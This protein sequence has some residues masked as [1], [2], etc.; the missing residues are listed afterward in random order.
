MARTHARTAIMRLRES[1]SSLE[2]YEAAKETGLM[3]R[4]K[5]VRPLMEVLRGGKRVLNWTAAA[6][7]SYLL[8]DE[9]AVPILESVVSNK[10]EHPKVRGQA[11][12]RLRFVIAKARVKGCS[13]IW[14]IRQRTCGSGA[15]TRSRKWKMSE[16]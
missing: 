3:D 9:R 8:H 13:R 11:Q 16:R 7:A 12:K 15:L 4:V 2:V 5:S 1:R 14:R 6:H 10:L